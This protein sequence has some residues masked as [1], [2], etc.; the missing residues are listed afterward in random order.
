MRSEHEQR[1]R[2]TS[3]KH[4][5][6]LAKPSKGK[7]KKSKKAKEAAAAAAAAAAQPAAKKLPP[8]ESFHDYVKARR[9]SSR[10][11]PLRFV[12]VGAL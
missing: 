12:P 3:E 4:Y 11:C 2:T 7:G 9:S 8:F 6:A 10:S 5:E 1:L